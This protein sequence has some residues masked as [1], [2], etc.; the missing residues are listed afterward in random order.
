MKNKITLALIAFVFVFIF[1]F[2]C[3]NLALGSWYE[4]QAHLWR[5][6]ETMSNYLPVMILAQVLLSIS[7]AL[8]FIQGY[9]NKGTSEAIRF[10]LIVGTLLASFDLVWFAV[11]P[12]FFKLLLAWLAIAYIKAI[13]L[14]FIFVKLYK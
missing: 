3:H 7:M 14:G 2:I 4:A 11:S 6:P 13:L 10:G 5:A 12:I 1:D 9:E 8:I